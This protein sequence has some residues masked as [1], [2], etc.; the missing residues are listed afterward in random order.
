MQIFMQF[1]LFVVVWM[2]ALT[3]GLQGVQKFCNFAKLELIESSKTYISLKSSIHEVSKYTWV[4][5]Q[6]HLLWSDCRSKIW[7]P[8]P[9]SARAFVWNDHLLIGN[10][11]IFKLINHYCVNLQTPI[12]LF[13]NSAKWCATKRYFCHQ[14]PSSSKIKQ[15]SD[16]RMLFSFPKLCRFLSTM[17]NL[18]RKNWYW[19]ATQIMIF[20]WLLMGNLCFT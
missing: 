13:S 9:F 3:P 15:C 5:Q 18:L 14:S 10:G 6:R 20:S 12:F 17:K 2:S 1:W 4:V 16:V 11:V 19:C 8:M 7:P